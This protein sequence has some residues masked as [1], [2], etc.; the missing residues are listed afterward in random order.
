MKKEILRSEA[1]STVR[2][3]VLANGMTILL[4]EVW[5]APICSWWVLYRVGS[6]EEAPGMTGA[7]HWVE[8]MMFRG[9]ARYPM[10]M[11]DN[12]IDRLGGVWNAQTAQD[13]T[14]Y[15]TTLPAAHIPLAL[16]AEA[17]RMRNLNFTEEDV[18][19]E[20][21]I[22]LA[23]R[24]STANDPLFALDEKM[25]HCAFTEHGY[26][27]EVLGEEKDLQRLD[28]G[29]L[30]EFY[31]Q[32]YHPANAIGVAVGAFD[33]EKLLSEIS[34]FFA[35][36]PNRY[37]S[38]PPRQP[39][40]EPPQTSERRFE[41]EHE[42][43]NEFIEIAYRAP[44]ATH[45]DWYALSV[46]GSLLAGPS[47]PGS[48]NV[49]N[50]TCRLYQAL[51]KTGL[52][53]AIDSNLSPRCDPYLYHLTITVQH[54][55]ELREVEEVVLATIDRMRM[56]EIGEDEISRAKKQTRALFAYSSEGVTGQG[57]WLSFTENF[58]GYE[59]FEGYV[60]RIEAVNTEQVIRAA[61]R[62]LR[63]EQRIVGWLRARS[64][65]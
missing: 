13:Y 18:E 43:E 25:N 50:R 55:R 7:A 8:H 6:K 48:G 2:R 64:S 10:G 46:L 3:H 22:I 62:Y 34:R 37:L 30:W 47:G 21:R 1:L 38:S 36:V 56:G 11:L 52:A 58:A 59:W 20:R 35:G 41:I 49:D 53:V 45:E 19:A 54:G 60:N 63:P 14:A 24:H 40:I 65:K 12:A 32:Y 16:E 5:H 51:V 28:H 57:F 27:H 44:Q 4:K 26:R 17:D 23:E 29:Q 15:Y 61:Q 39:R 33:S 9:T 42:G 31:Q